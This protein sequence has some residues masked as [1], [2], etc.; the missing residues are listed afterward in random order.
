[1]LYSVHIGFPGIN[2]SRLLGTILTLQNAGFPGSLHGDGNRGDGWLFESKKP[3]TGRVLGDLIKYG[4]HLV[5]R[6]RE[7]VF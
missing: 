4:V 5:E 7:Y 2:D 6:E 1:M 3:V